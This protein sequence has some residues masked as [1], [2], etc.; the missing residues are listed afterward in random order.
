MEYE[1]DEEAN[2]K[3]AVKRQS[4]LSSAVEWITDTYP[5]KFGQKIHASIDNKNNITITGD[6]EIFEN[7]SYQKDI[8]YN[9]QEE[10]YNII[11]KIK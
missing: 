1:K 10:K 8:E 3:N 7:E 6:L 9:G 4:I 11:L 2:F 5:E